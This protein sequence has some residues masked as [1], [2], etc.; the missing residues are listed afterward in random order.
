MNAEKNKDSISDDARELE[1]PDWLRLELDRRIAAADANPSAALSW[2]E[3]KASLPGSEV[4]QNRVRRSSARHN[5]FHHNRRCGSF[6]TASLR[7]RVR[8]DRFLH[9]SQNRLVALNDPASKQF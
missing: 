8:V 3:V 5:R 7:Q 6:A 9:A 1:M 2:D 4:R